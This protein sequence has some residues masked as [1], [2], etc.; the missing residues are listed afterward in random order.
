MGTRG[1][2]DTLGTGLDI[3]D[4]KLDSSGNLWAPHNVLNTVDKI[5]IATG[6][7]LATYSAVGNPTGLTI[8]GDGNVYTYGADGWLYRLSD[9]VGV[10]PTAIYDVQLG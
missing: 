7:V 10:L 4:I 5:D 9:Q 6:T 3:Y 2:L 8:G 1:C